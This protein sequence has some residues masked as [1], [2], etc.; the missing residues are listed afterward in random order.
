[1]ASHHLIDTYLAE[2]AP[3]LPA[4]IVDELADG[5]EETFEHHRRRGLRPASAAAAATAEFGHPDQITR[6]FTRQSPGRR[7]ALTLLA[8]G[9]LFA[10]LWSTSLITA[11][12]WT[13]TI[14]T[15]A[16]VTFGA[17][18]LATAAVLVAVVTSRS[19]VRTRL[20]GPACG[21]LILLD[22]AMLAAIALAAPALSWPLAL[23]I[24]ASL[25]RIGI[26]ARNL[27]RILA[28]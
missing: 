23:A 7:T 6:A 25:A 2:L 16:A 4:N 18:L 24:P 12:A 9:P 10:A 20:A 15:G 28:R 17:T 3:Q 8:T 14:P 27:P 13:W 11:Q 26:A 22:A 21:S 1:M 5:L 19:Y